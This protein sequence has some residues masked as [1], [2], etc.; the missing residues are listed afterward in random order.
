VSNLVDDDPRKVWIVDVQIKVQMAVVAEDEDDAR[1]VAR[2]HLAGEL[3]HDLH[4]A[5]YTPRLLNRPLHLIGGLS[6]PLGGTLPWG[7]DQEDDPRRNWC[8]EQWIGMW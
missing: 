8:I 4:N 7:V 1:C 3:E 2:K 5:T 6:G